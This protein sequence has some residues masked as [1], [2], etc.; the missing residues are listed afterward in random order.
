[1]FKMPCGLIVINELMIKHLALSRAFEIRGHYKKGVRA[2]AL[3]AGPSTMAFHEAP[4]G[5]ILNADKITAAQHKWIYS[6]VAAGYLTD[7]IWHHYGG[8]FY[9]GAS[10]F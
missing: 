9:K 6:A 3:F 5:G 1:M 2:R 7:S 10:V 4:A 8:G